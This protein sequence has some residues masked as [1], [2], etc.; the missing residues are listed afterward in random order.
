MT[1]GSVAFK[2]RVSR[3]LLRHLSLA[4]AAEWQQSDSTS[5]LEVV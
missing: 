1:N 2:H 3:L 4:G 5:V